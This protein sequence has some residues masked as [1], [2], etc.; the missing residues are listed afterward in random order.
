MSDLVKKLFTVIA[1]AMVAAKTADDRAEIVASVADWLGKAVAIA[2][3]DDREAAAYLLETAVLQA[4]ATAAEC[5]PAGKRFRDEGPTAG[6][7]ALS[8]KGRKS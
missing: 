3:A 5:L 7:V 6:L 4:E 2:S 8:A 1:P